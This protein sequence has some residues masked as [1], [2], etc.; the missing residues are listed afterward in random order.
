MSTT[1]NQITCYKTSHQPPHPKLGVS[2]VLGI[3][4]ELSQG[5]WFGEYSTLPSRG[6]SGLPGSP[7]MVA[8][9]HVTFHLYMASF[10]FN[11]T[12]PPPPRDLQAWSWS[13]AL[14]PN[15][16]HLWTARC[17]LIIAFKIIS[18]E[19]TTEG[20]PTNLGMVGKGGPGTGMTYLMS[21]S[22]MFTPHNKLV[23]WNLVHMTYEMRSSGTKWF[24]F[25]LWKY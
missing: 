25:Y 19:R 9:C 22:F 17:C 21:H 1:L 13:Q 3:G 7:S 2:F 10:L 24:C 5:P 16:L 23:F 20:L 6:I 4:A 14:S 15:K 11:A 8:L 12:P 18:N